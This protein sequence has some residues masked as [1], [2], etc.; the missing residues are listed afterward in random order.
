MNLTAEHIWFS[1]VY[2]ISNDIRVKIKV[3]GSDPSEWSLK[4]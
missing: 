3:T 2:G 4:D 1:R